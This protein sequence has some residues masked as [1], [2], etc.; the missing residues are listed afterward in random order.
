[1]ETHVAIIF[2]V[3][4]IIGESSC[5]WTCP[6]IKTGPPPDNINNLRPTDISLVMALGDSIT[7]GFAMRD[8]WWF[9]GWFEY[10]GDSFSIG[11]DSD[12][13]TIPN[14]LLNYSPHLT[15]YSVGFRDGFDFVNYNS[16]DSWIPHEP[17]IDHLN[18]AIS[19]ACVMHLDMEIDYL[20]S[21][22]SMM[23]NQGIL[24]DD[25][26]KLL[27]IL[28]GANNLCAF[29]LNNSFSD[30]QYI[31]SELERD[32]EKIYKN[33]PRTFV[34]LLLLMNVE[35]VY[36][37]SKSGEVCNYVQVKML[38]ECPCVE[39][40]DTREEMIQLV[41]VYNS[42]LQ[43]I[44]QKWKAKNL[45]DFAVVIQ[46]FLQQSVL[47]K[48]ELSPLDCFHPNQYGDQLMAIG[49]WNN[50]LTPSAQKKNTI[51]ENDVPLCPNNETLLYTY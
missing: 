34:N 5:E 32:L 10:R 13:M 4:L 25:Q 36:Y 42:I 40:N 7:A 2:L 38:D 3:V 1:M 15:G 17:L 43:N 46:P 23:K 28:I 44:S 45:D 9:D 48:D 30:P 41:E 47:T 26:W 8:K 37:M 19:G 50:M 6:P 31:Q 16:N 27:T 14:F 29:C 35:Q 33:F 20:I 12:L 24:S 22:T 11:G 39:A 18:A 49:L 21:Q 51:N